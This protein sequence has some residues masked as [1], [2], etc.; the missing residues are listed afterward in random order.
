MDG[1]YLKLLNKMWLPET[2]PEPFYPSDLTDCEWQIIDFLL[3]LEKQR[4]RQR[5]VDFQQ[6]VNAIFYRAD[7]GIKWRAMPID[8]PAWQTVYGYYQ[9]VKKGLWESINA[10]LVEQ[11]RTR[12]GRAEQPSLGMIDSQSIKRAQRGQLEQGFDGYKKVKGRKR[13]VVVDVL[14]LMLGCFVSAANVADGK[15][16]PAV[17]VPVLE[18][19]KRLEKVLADQAY[20]GELDSCLQAAYECVL[21]IAPPRQIKGFHVESLRWIVERTFAW[22]DNARVLCP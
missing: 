21:E 20:K 7:N 4:G 22:L 13:H 12:A 2:M 18:L 5:Q 19:Y 14:G 17:L 6:V 16:A 8:F 9:W 10:L 11:V 15:A 3:P 1:G